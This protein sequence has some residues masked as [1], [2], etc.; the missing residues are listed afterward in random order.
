M[1]NWY[2]YCDP[3]DVYTCPRRMN[4]QL[5]SLA[6]LSL[7]LSLSSTRLSSSA[8][9]LL[10]QSLHW[11]AATIQRHGF[12]SPSLPP[13][14]RLSWTPATLVAQDRMALVIAKKKQVICDDGLAF[15]L[16]SPSRPSPSKTTPPHNAFLNFFSHT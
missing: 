8:S 1:H 10:V 3:D 5:I 11:Q 16:T 6:S 4:F 14:Q 7:C 13:L 15:Q 9:L 12:F 2:D